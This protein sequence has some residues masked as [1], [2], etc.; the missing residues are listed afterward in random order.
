MARVINVGVAISFRQEGD[1]IRDKAMSARYYISTAKFTAKE[2]AEAIKAHWLIE[3]Q[4]HW[5]LDVGMREDECRIHRGD[6]AENLA[7]FRYV[8][9]NLLTNEKTM[10]AGIKRKRL[11]AALSPDYPESLRDRGF[12]N[13]ALGGMSSYCYEFTDGG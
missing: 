11:K 5:K 9:M 6:A 7:G 4:L 10:K 2:F 3:V 1:N 13:L 12:R 8:T